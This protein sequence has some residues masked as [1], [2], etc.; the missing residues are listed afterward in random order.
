MEAIVAG[1]KVLQGRGVER[2][3]AAE[4]LRAAPKLAQH[5]GDR[6]AEQGNN[7][8]LI[9]GNRSAYLAAR[10]KRDHPEIA[11]RVEA[12]GRWRRWRTA[13]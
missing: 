8:T 9:R 1:V 12:A 6:K 5:G 4:A 11:A 3:S 13:S 10:L 2:M 7:G